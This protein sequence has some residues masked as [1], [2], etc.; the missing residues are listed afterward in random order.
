M[1]PYAYTGGNP[2]NFVDPYG[3]EKINLL[4]VG[5]SANWAEFFMPDIPGVIWVTAHG[6]PQ[7]AGGMDADE[8]AQEIRDS[9]YWAPGKAVTLNACNTGKGKDSIAQKLSKNLHTTVTAPDGYAWA[10]GPLETGIW[11]KTADG[12]VDLSNPGKWVKF[13]DGVPVTK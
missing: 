10:W 4:P 7:R 11:G 6:N 3:L 13:K 2:V 8:L 9:G 12:N 1:N 5:D